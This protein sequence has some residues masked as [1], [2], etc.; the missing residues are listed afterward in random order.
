MKWKPNNKDKRLLYREGQA[1]ETYE[2]NIESAFKK[3]MLH[4][5]K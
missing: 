3:Q 1:S 2:K 4:K 5:E